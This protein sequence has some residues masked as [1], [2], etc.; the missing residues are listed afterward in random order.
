MADSMTAGIL[1]FAGG[2][3]ITTLIIALM[4]LKTLKKPD[5]THAQRK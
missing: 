5:R 1:F 3:V 4:N 2:I